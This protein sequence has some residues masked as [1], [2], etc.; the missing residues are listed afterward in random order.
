MEV[1]REQQPH[2]DKYTEAAER[3]KVF[4]NIHKID[5]DIRD[6]SLN[7]D[8]YSQQLSALRA[9]RDYVRD[10][11]RAES[12][13]TN[14]LLPDKGI[15]FWKDALVEVYGPYDTPRDERQDQIE[16]CL[17]QA[18]IDF[19]NNQDDD[20]FESGESLQKTIFG[21]SNKFKINSFIRSNKE[22]TVRIRSISIRLD[23]YMQ[24]INTTTPTRT[25]YKPNEEITECLAEEEVNGQK[26]QTFYGEIAAYL[27]DVD[28]DLNPGG[29]YNVLVFRSYHGGEEKYLGL[30][31]NL[32]MLC[33]FAMGPKVS[34]EHFDQIQTDTADTAV[35]NPS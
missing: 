10:G 17:K 11:V 25:L 23:I 22:R 1:S 18:E 28:S 19:P 16:Q 35:A 2:P 15:I 27:T 20:S 31:T 14:I 13:L 30:N 7:G 29:G 26:A 8:A 33:E 3:A 6:D 4:N 21:L 5:Q 24:P 9:L 12:V 32:A 34:D